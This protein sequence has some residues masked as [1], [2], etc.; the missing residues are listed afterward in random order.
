MNDKAQCEGLAESSLLLEL[1][2]MVFS[3]W[4][5]KWGG[6]IHK[7]P[8]WNGNG[9]VPHIPCHKETELLEEL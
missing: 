8:P 2:K 5:W 3:A 4:E 6:M 1:R 7:A 9:I